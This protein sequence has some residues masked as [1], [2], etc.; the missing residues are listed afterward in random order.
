MN[1]GQLNAVLYQISRLTADRKARQQTDRELLERFMALQ[2]QAAFAALVERHGSLVLS[3]CRRVLPHSHDAEDACQAAFLVL[4]R[5]AGSIRK[6]D[7]L[8]SWLHGV[9]YRSAMSLR[10]HLSRHHRREAPLKDIASS[11]R[12]DELTW[13][14][15]LGALDA[16]LE[17]LPETLRAPL[18]LCYLQG[19]TRDEAAQELGWKVPTLRGRL[20][21]GRRLL[22]SRLT[23]R[24]LALSAALLAPALARQATA[25]VSPTRVMNTVKA[26]ILLAAG[27]TSVPGM[28]P[29]RVTSALEGVLQTMFVSKL[30]MV[31]LMVLT[32]GLVGTGAGTL[33]YRSQA[34]QALQAE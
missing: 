22:R 31:A 10:R 7:S 24:G 29:A 14:E 8:A 18:V 25:A 3:V 4:A 15:V 21:R 6:R 11:T 34:A 33:A 2:D 19:K 16:E 26:A 23:R 12:T 32:V 17:R 28:I 13:R 27:H 5:K 1:N 20:E 9:A 30:K